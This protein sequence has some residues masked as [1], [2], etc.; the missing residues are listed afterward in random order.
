MLCELVLLL[1]VRSTTSFFLGYLLALCV[2]VTVYKTN[3]KTK[4]GYSHYSHI[5]S[6]VYLIGSYARYMYANL[7]TFNLVLA[8]CLAACQLYNTFIAQVRLSHYIQAS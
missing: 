8:L 7:I 6:E 3:H 4:Q 2:S 1:V 5:L